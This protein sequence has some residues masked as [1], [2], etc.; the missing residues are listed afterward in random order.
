MSSAPRVPCRFCEGKY[1]P[2]GITNHETYCS[3]NPN[4]GVPVEKQRDLGI[5]PDADVDDVD[6]DDDADTDDAVT[7]GGNEL[8]ERETLPADEPES[9]ETTESIGNSHSCPECGSSNTI[10][11]FQARQEFEKRLSTFPDGLRT[12]LDATNRYCNECFSVWGGELSE[13]H[14][15]VGGNA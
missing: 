8:P 6:A 14:Q 4:E 12:T 1:E 13:P 11:A 9:P 2:S 5:L 15:I 10:T 3:E 7:D